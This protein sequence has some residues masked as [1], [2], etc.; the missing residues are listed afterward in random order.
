MD[1]RPLAPTKAVAAVLCCLVAAMI[2]GC[3]SSGRG[4]AATPGDLAARLGCTGS[5]TTEQSS[6]LF[7]RESGRCSIDGSDVTLYTY[8]DNDSRDNWV[9][10]AQTFGGVLV[11]GDRWTARAPSQA[12]AETVKGKIGGTI[13]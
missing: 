8:A 7:V 10:S 12:A 13:R 1:R 4:T 6:E 3:S 2:T 11:V 5:F 9:K